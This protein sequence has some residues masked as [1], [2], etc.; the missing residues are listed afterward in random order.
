MKLRDII[1]AFKTTEQ[2]AEIKGLTNNDQWEVYKVRKNLRTHIDFMNERLS[3]LQAKYREFADENGV[4]NGDKAIEYNKELEEL[5]NMEIDMNDY[6]IPVVHMAE[7]ITFKI[8]EP[9]EN[10]IEFTPD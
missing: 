7:G 2:L 9:L 3:A 6:D 1:N 5:N 10:I 8:M 4:L